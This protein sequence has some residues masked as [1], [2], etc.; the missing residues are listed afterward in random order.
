MNFPVRDLVTAI[1]EKEVKNDAADD[2]HHS[3][4]CEQESSGDIM[5][6]TYEKEN[7]ILWSVEVINIAL[8]L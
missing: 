5:E 4:S 2:D 6:A 3:F 8:S 7:I 1:S